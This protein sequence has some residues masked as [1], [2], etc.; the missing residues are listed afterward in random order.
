MPQS[1]RQPIPYARD[2]ART[3]EIVQ[4]MP[5]TE[6]I[7]HIAD[8]AKQ[9]Q[10]IS[11][12]PVAR[13]LRR[14]LFVWFRVYVRETKYGKSQKVNVSIPLPIPLLGATFARQLSLQ[15]AAKIAAQARSGQ[16]LDE[17]L[18]SE[19]GFEFVRVHE[20]QPERGKSQ[21]VVV[22]LD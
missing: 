19:M 20:E 9:L 14:L 15:K 13:S 21:L 12:V 2:N 22:G 1:Q 4:D 18:E 5:R 8:E 6:R 11:Q 7:I 10:E 16:D 17:L 3:I